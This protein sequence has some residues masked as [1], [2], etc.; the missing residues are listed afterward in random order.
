MVSK[1]QVTIAVWLILCL[2][3]FFFP[4]SLRFVPFRS[5]CTANAKIKQQ[6]DIL[7]ERLLRQEEND[8]AKDIDDDGASTLKRST[9]IRNHEQERDELFQALQHCLKDAAIV[10]GCSMGDDHL[11]MRYL[12]T[13]FEEHDVH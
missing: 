2:F 5:I 1:P 6:L 10:Q 3:L 7:R 9:S 4:F 13:Y 11:A 8:E 12:K